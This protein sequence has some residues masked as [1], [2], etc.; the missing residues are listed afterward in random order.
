MQA[1][2][3]TKCCCAIQ[4]GALSDFLKFDP[5]LCKD[6]IFNIIENTWLKTCYAAV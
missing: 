6:Q 3:H 2:D 5:D 4:N 1:E